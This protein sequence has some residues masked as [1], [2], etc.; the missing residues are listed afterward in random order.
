MMASVGDKIIVEAKKAAQPGREGV[1]EE[2]LQEDPPRYSVRWS[3][4]RLSIFTPSAGVA[5][6]EAAKKKKARASKQK[7]K[8]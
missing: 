1:I 6:I 3:D 4:G 5:T 2:V 8:R 7:A